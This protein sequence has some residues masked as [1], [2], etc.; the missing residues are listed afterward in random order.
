MQSS[1]MP[2]AGCDLDATNIQAPIPYQ[3]WVI[4]FPDTM[5]ASCS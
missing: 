1:M 2:E 4:R 5:P 3:E